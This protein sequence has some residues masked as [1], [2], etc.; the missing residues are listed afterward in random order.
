MIDEAELRRQAAASGVGLAIADLDYGLG[1]LLASL[2]RH[3]QSGTLRFKG[4]TCLRKCYHADYRF[5]VDLDFTLAGQL[6]RRALRRLLEQVVGAATDEWEMDFGAGPLKMETVDDDYG[7]ESHSAR[8]YY[9][10]PLRMR[11]DPRAVRIDVTTV[12]TLAFA[13]AVR[14]IIHPYSDRGLLADVRVPCYTPLE[15]AAEKVRALCGQRKYAISRDVYDLDQ[16]S[17]RHNLDMGELASALPAKF[18]AKGLD[19]GGLDVG[20]LHAREQDFRQDWSRNLVHLIG[21]APG[22]SFDEAW[23]NS[24]SL[25]QLLARTLRSP[26]PSDDC[27]GIVRS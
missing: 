13:P 4:G 14:P 3:P 15:M 11:G 10:G 18:R 1:C 19:I 24:T 20:K 9:R 26:G 6:D 16:L 8:L 7:R 23:R 5:S 27:E 2:F 12:E 17:R 22:T 21:P 25:L